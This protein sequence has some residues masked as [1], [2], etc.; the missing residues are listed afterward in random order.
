VAGALLDAARVTEGDRVLD[1]ATGPGWM[2]AAAMARG[3]RV[4]GLDVSEAMAAEATSRHPGLEVEVSPAETMPFGDGSFD[5]VISAFGMPHFADH[6]AVFA[7]AHRVLAPG[8]RIAVA[9]WNPPA[10]NPFFAVALGSI[11]QAGS[12]DVDLPAGVDMFAWADDEPC[13]ELFDGAGFGP[14]TRDQVELTFV[15]DDGPGMMKQ[16]LENA[17]VRSR[18]LYRAQTDEA[19]AAISA[20]ISE[21]LEPMHDG[22]RWTIPTT[23]FVLSAVRP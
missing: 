14:F 7:E 20:K 21:L 2:A 1:V 6:A 16:L 12:L 9:S 19:K 22:G 3:A 17:S 23:A 8:G 10:S 13:H 15:T 4:T 18:A 11:A 5:A